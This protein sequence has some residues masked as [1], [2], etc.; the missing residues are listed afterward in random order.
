MFK[1]CGTYDPAISDHRISYGELSEKV[2]KHKTKTITFRL[3]KNTDL[4]EL[5]RDLNDAPWH[6]GDVFSDRDEKYYDWRTLFQS[7]VDK[8]APLKRKEQKR[9]TFHI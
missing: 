2:R 1:K 7:I 6:V 8:H 5:N 3:T 4:D 9:R